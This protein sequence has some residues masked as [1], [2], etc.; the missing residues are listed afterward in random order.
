MPVFLA[1][2]KRFG[3]Q[4]GGP[5]SFPLAGWT[6][7]VDLPARAPGLQERLRELDDVVAA[8]GGRVYL[9]KDV[10][11][12]GEHLREMYPR[13]GELHQLRERVDPHGTLRSDL[14]LRLGLVEAAA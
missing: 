6:L 1:V 2:F 10:R 14:A 13:L 11:M 3:E 5:L 12:A 7:A 4:F 9:A 8:A